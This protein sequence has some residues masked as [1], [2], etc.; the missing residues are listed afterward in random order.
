MFSSRSVC[1]V[2]AFVF[3]DRVNRQ[4]RK[5]GS[6]AVVFEVGIQNQDSLARHGERQLDAGKHN[7]P[8]LWC[9]GCAVGVRLCK[10]GPNE[11]HVVVVSNGYRIETLLRHAATSRP[12]YAIRSG[13]VTQSAPDHCLSRGE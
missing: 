11:G 3:G 5:D 6:E 4:C 1:A 8:L 10:C 9:Q 2:F 7:Q 12:A 13:S